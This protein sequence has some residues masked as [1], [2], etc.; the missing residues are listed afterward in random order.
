MVNERK[1]KKIAEKEL[2]RRKAIESLRKGVS[3]ADAQI[4]KLSGVKVPPLSQVYNTDI[5][6]SY[7]TKLTDE[8]YASRLL[9]RYDETRNETTPEVLQEILRDQKKVVLSNYH[10]NRKLGLRSIKGLETSKSPGKD[11]SALQRYCQQLT[12]FRRNPPD[13]PSTSEPPRKPK[14][15]RKK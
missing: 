6:S 1:Q 10:E 12:E 5:V 8:G 13:F 9:K 15:L 14:F 2:D 3:K 11:F 4:E 7:Y